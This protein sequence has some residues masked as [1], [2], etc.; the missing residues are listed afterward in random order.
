[1]KNLTPKGF[2][3]IIVLILVLISSGFF[4]RG[5]DTSFC[6]KVTGKV[7]KL[8]KTSSNYYFAT[9]IYND[10]IVE[11]KIIR[12]NNEFK[13]DIKNK[14]TYSILIAK[15]GYESKLI[16]VD[17]KTKKNQNV[18][19]IETELVDGSSRL[20]SDFKPIDSSVGLVS[21]D[22][23]KRWFNY[24]SIYKSSSK[25]NFYANSTCKN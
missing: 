6:I 16:Q 20:K 4:A 10:Q 17:A 3:L 24:N 9:L 21:F 2:L 25:K 15:E 7:L 19:Y 12:G 8:K 5:N 1:M 14:G 18:F 11:S 13:F 22:P 23:K